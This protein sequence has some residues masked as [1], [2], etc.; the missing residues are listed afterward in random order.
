MLAAR[1]FPV[2]CAIDERPGRGQSR[3][4]F[5]AEA[6]ERRDRTA[7]V[8]VSRC[9]RIGAKRRDADRVLDAGFVPRRRSRRAEVTAIVISSHGAHEL[10]HESSCARACAPVSCA[11]VAVRYRAYLDSSRRVARSDRVGHLREM[12]RRRARTR[13]EEARIDP[14]A[15]LRSAIASDF[16]ARPAKTAAD[17]D[18]ADVDIRGAAVACDRLVLGHTGSMCLR[19]LCLRVRATHRALHLASSMQ[20]DVPRFSMGP[21]TR[22]YRLTIE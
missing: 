6:L 16:V 4:G 19:R 18:R 12:S 5:T 17:R 7:R 3:H 8:D 10:L 15:A 9:E 13:R 14:E 11:A 1:F 22:R 20:R 21:T 2:A